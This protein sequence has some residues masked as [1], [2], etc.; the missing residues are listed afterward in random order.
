MGEIR[1]FRL[2]WE[3]TG[4]SPV[5]GN[6]GNETRMYQ[7]AY[8]DKQSA[9]YKHSREGNYAVDPSNFQILAKGYQNWKDRKICEAL[10][11]KDYKPFLN[12]QKDSHKLELFT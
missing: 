5:R 4:L 10:F 1:L 11:V 3:R 9:I 6:G 2:L 8:T 12:K 7:Y